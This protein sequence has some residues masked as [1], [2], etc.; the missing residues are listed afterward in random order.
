MKQMARH[1][2]LAMPIQSCTLLLTP[3]LCAITQ[4]SSCLFAVLACLVKV[5]QILVLAL[6]KSGSGC[7]VVLGLC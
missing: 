7:V 1:E 2:T 5:D 3:Y 4:C 6:L